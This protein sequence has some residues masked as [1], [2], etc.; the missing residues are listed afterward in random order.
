MNNLRITMQWLS[1]VNQQNIAKSL[2]MQVSTRGREIYNDL[3]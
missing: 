3:Y 2:Q 1:R